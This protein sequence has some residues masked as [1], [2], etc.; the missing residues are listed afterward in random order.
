MITDLIT[1][2]V[3]LSLDLLNKLLPTFS[4]D[5]EVVNNATNVISTLNDF[6]VKVNFI[7][8]LPDILMIVSIDLSIRVFKLSLFIGEKVKKTILGI[9]P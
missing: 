4:M 8:P 7:I 6:L 3:S 5:P 9:I 2:V 1:K